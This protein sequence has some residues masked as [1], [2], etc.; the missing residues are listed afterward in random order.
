MPAHSISFSS[1]VSKVSFHEFMASDSTSYASTSTLSYTLAIA[2]THTD[3]HPMTAAESYIASINTSISIFTE[4]SI[5]HVVYIDAFEKESN[6][7]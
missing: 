5:N 4:S 3:T 7:E 1:R 2:R 6:K